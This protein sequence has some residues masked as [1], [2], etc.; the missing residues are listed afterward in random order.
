MKIGRFGKYIGNAWR[1][2]KCGAGEGRRR[3]SGPIVWRMKYYT[4]EGMKG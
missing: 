4:E 3:S 2:S 1:V